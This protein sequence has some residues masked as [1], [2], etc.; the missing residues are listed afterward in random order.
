[1]PTSKRVIRNLGRPI[2]HTNKIIWQIPFIQNPKP[3]TLHYVKGAKI[4]NFKVKQVSKLGNEACERQNWECKNQVR[5][6]FDSFHS[7]FVHS[8]LPCIENILIFGF[9]LHTTNNVQWPLQENCLHPTKRKA[10]ITPNPHKANE[11]LSHLTLNSYVFSKSKRCRS[12]NRCWEQRQ[13]MYGSCLWG[14]G[15]LNH[16][17]HHQ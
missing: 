7:N 16:F 13:S 2:N 6:F 3:K 5:S 10:C 17:F 8:L 12:P 14:G 9:A 11:L 15:V 1:M 4:S